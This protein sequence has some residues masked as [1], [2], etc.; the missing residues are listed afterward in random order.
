[1]IAAVL[2]KFNEPLE[3]MSVRWQPVNYGQV[4]VQVICSGICGAQISE[5]R[6]DKNGDIPK[7][8]LMG[9]EA[10]VRVMKVGA[11]VK[12]LKRDDK[13]IAHWRKG[14]G[15]ES[16]HP[17]W[18]SE[19]WNGTAGKITT[20]SMFSVISENRLT[21]VPEDTPDEL[22]MLIGCSLSTALGVVENE[23]NIRIGERVLIIGCGG[24]GINLILAAKMR[25][26]AEIYVLEKVKEKWSLAADMGALEFWNEIP[27]H[28][29]PGIFDVAIDTTGDS[30][31]IAAGIASLKP[32]GRFVM[33]GQPKGDVTIPDA[34]RMFEGS[35]KHIM[36]TQGGRFSPS[37]DIPRFIQAWR[38]G[39]IK[40]DGIISHRFPLNEINAALDCVRQGHAGRVMID[41]AS[42]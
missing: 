3:L 6:G 28:R 4:L 36:A 5:I 41:C 35:G 34:K 2:T 24:L 10:C 33:V 27:K 32:S 18:S 11:G 14:D 22:A 21:R 12:S 37:E 8:R 23:A 13:A 38:A 17:L 15:I 16:D 31:A 7:P 40:L 26:A 20:F 39:L 25:Q 1:M 9:H 19:D 42:E 29:T 30:D